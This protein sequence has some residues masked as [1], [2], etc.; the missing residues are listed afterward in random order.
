LKEKK[1]PEKRLDIGSTDQI[2]MG[3]DDPYPLGEMESEEQSSYPGKILDLALEEK[4]IDEAQ[5]KEIWCDNV[6]KWICGKDDTAFKNRIS[7]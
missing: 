7:K 5:H 3:L 4:I 6:V 1:D 2:L